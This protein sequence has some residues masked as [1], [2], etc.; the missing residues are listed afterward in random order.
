[1]MSLTKWDLI[2]APLGPL[3]LFFQ[4]T[5]LFIYSPGDRYSV[6]PFAIPP[7]AFDFGDSD[8]LLVLE[9]VNIITKHQ[10]YL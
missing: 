5:N 1:M 2:E 6:N 4:A 9:A 3:V 8:L 7:C 10:H